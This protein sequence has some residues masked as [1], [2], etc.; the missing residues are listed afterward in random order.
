MV[1]PTTDQSF[2]G[3]HSHPV[4][5]LASPKNCVKSL[6]GT[7]IPTLAGA[8]SFSQCE[9]PWEISYFCGVHCSDSL[10]L[11]LGDTDV[12]FKCLHISQAGYRATL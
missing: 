7:P 12:S 2:S 5:G 10:M 4:G 3:L 6:S 8:L 9:I 11:R 1:L